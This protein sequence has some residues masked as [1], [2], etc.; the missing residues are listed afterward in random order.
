MNRRSWVE[1]RLWHVAAAL[2][3]V[4]V[5]A[6]HL[7]VTPV[8]STRY[9]HDLVVLVGMGARWLQGLRPHADFYSPFGPVP[10]ALFGSAMRA[11]GGHARGV[12]WVASTMVAPALGLALVAL[13]GRP[14]AVARAALAFD[15][16]LLTLGVRVLDHPP[17]TFAY[18]M[19]YNRFEFAALVVIM[20]AMFLPFDEGR[21][22]GRWW[23]R[24]STRAALVAGLLTAALLWCKL[25][26]GGAAGAFVLTGAWLQPS[27]RRRAA[28]GAFGL[29]FACVSIPALI[30]IRWDIAGMARDLHWAT[31]ARSAK[32]TSE[33]L[34]FTLRSGGAAF[35]S[36][37]AVAAVLAVFSRM[38]PRRRVELVALGAVGTLCSA[39]ISLGN[40]VGPDYSIEAPLAAPLIALLMLRA[41][42]DEVRR[43]GMVLAGAVGLALLLAFVAND[44][45]A[46]RG[47][48]L[49][50][51]ALAARGPVAPLPGEIWR[52]LDIG[53]YDG[54]CW[55]G[56]PV[57]LAR[58]AVDLIGSSPLARAPVAMLDF[59]DVVTLSRGAPFPRY[60]PPFWQGGINIS[61]RSRPPPE[62][63]F[64]DARGVL[65]ANCPD[66]PGVTLLLWDLYRPY[67]SA[68]FRMLRRTRE[69]TLLIRR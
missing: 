11:A 31:L 67:I 19:I 50:R 69:W 37:L 65:L 16:A 33:V 46:F 62:F 35:V 45:A 27:L 40:S 9:A 48:M 38:S 55:R 34:L 68:H 25:N 2:G 6:A 60:A 51:S 39:V 57:A 10:Y 7:Y 8:A 18:G 17:E 42:G 59:S 52:G 12:A 28:L 24:P 5:L 23:V 13:V 47:A 29:G 66:D 56:R 22:S 49:R 53:G 63:V 36:P 43:A 20:G 14:G 61:R 4:A 3:I 15:V 30:A 1:S 44:G 54:A 26:F 64:R 21:E 58:E 41:S 32:W